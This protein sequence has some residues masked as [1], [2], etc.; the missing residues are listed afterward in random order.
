MELELIYTPI[1]TESSF[2]KVYNFN[3]TELL[4]LCA[5][6]IKNQNLDNVHNR[7]VGF[8]TDSKYTNYYHGSVLIAHSR[9]LPD[10][11]KILLDKINNIFEADCNCILV[12]RYI[13]GSHIIP[14]HRDSMNHA[15]VGVIILSYGDTRIFRIYDNNSNQICN[16]S[17]VHNQLIQMGGDFQREFLHDLK[18]EPDKGERI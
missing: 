1:Q 8:F 6:Y 2:L 11:M 9:A 12:N 14:K 13:D 15:N 17:F 7:L 5:Q 16:L 10:N 4:E 18:R 3:D